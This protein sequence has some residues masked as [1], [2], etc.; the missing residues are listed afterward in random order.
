MKLGRVRSEFAG[1]L[2]ILRLDAEGVAERTVRRRIWFWTSWLDGSRRNTA[3]KSTFGWV[4]L[5][6]KICSSEG[7]D[8]GGP[9][10]VDGPH[11]PQAFLAFALGST[12]IAVSLHM[13]CSER[14]RNCCRGFS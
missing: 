6:V 2:L 8:L 10:S 9:E 12:S 13:R 3:W 7:N 5:V 1:K 4:S 11:C 14:V